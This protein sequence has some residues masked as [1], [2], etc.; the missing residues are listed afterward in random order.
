MDGPGRAECDDGGVGFLSF[1]QYLIHDRDGKYCPAFQRII[2]D[3]GVQCVPLP[4]RSLYLNA[5]AERWVRSVKAEAL[6][7]LTLF[8]ER[9]LR[10]ALTQYDT[11][12][13]TERPQAH[14]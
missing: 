3:A 6:S 1:G 2:D 11:H 13:H 8:G 5:H 10:H 14:D 7:R 9:S 4:S 12:Y